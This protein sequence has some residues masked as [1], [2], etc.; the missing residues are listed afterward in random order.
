MYWTKICGIILI[1]LI[2]S[3]TGKAQSLQF[4]KYNT[5]PASPAKSLFKID[6]LVNTGNSSQILP[7]TL[8]IIPADYYTQHFG[9]FCK[10]ELM[11]EKI[12]KIPL[13]FR[14]G[15]LQPCSY[16]EGNK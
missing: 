2:A 7:A 15:S 1:F 8:Q 9:F 6:K 4:V 14:L 16:L 12:T 3:F 5:H 11:M 13:R 10:K